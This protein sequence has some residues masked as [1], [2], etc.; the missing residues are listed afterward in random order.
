MQTNVDPFTKQEITNDADPPFQ[1]F[2]D[3]S[4]FLLSYM[5]PPMIMP[6]NKSGDVIGN[7]G[8]LIK[9]GMAY[10]FIDGNIDKD[11]LPKTSIPESWL[12]WSGVNFSKLDEGTS[13]RKIKFKAREVQATIGRLKKFLKDPNLSEQQRQRLISEYRA[14]ILRI[15]TELQEL[16]NAYSKVRDVL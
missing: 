1:Q 7:G 8:Q 6:R 12:S 16:K 9:T 2:Q 15:Q 13:K 3:M 11:G 14:N 5:L 10:G 4:A